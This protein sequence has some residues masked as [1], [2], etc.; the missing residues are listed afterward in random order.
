MAA[1]LRQRRVRDDVRCERGG[2]GDGD[3]G[4]ERFHNERSSWTLSGNGADGSGGWLPV[5]RRGKKMGTD[6]GAAG[7]RQAA[8]APFSAD[9][10]PNPARFALLT[11][12]SGGM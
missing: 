9:Q 1:G 5:A 4:A 10:R 11:P 12:A 8:A 6:N 2:R 3:A 7:S